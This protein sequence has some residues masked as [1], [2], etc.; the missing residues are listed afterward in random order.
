MISLG[1]TFQTRTAAELK[2]RPPSVGRRIAG[3]SKADEE[4]ERSLERLEREETAVNSA[5]R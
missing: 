3:L 5:V 1:K 2:D 4:L